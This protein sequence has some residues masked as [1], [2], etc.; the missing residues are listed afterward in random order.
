VWGAYAIT[1]PPALGAA[2][3]TFYGGFFV[4][5]LFAFIGLM[6]SAGP[7]TPQRPGQPPMGGRR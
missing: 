5:L 7:S 2:F 6:L 4:L 3:F 1:L